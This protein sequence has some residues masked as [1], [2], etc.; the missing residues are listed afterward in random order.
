M[1]REKK[2]VYIVAEIGGNFTDYDTA[3]LLID[4]AKESGADAVKL[5]TYKANTVASKQAMFDMENTGI[6]RQTEYFKKFE[7]DMEMHE[8][9]YAY[10]RKMGLDIFS[11]PS[12]MSDVDMLE[13]LGTNVY[14]IGADD[15]TNIPFLKGVARLGKTIMLSTGMS[16]L[17]EVREAV[18]AILEEGNE[19]IVI[20]HVVSL[21]PTA[22]QY[23]NLEA[24]RTLQREF[25]QF[26]VG[27]SDHTLGIDSCIF[28]A[29][30]GARV[31]EKHFTYDKQA[32][33]PDHMLSATMDEMKTLVEKIRLYEEMRGHGVKMPMGDEL[34][35]R[36]NNRKSIVC[37]H[38]IKRGEVL[39]E[40][41]VDIKRPGF[42]IPPKYKA[43]LIG[44]RAVRDIEDDTVIRWADFE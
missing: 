8:K 19:D 5:Q 10:A 27:Y 1:F 25:P 41:N 22:P 23:V 21:Y 29:V 4:Q 28:A 35:N 18:N 2:R 7:L 30:M 3:T 36:K 14:K 9:V 31:I 34:K 12:H 6:I 42:G 43:V 32:E 16:T 40:D 17:E 13:K 44:K 24:I 15:V 38:G 20:M 37:V 11:T 39:T 26:T 33:G